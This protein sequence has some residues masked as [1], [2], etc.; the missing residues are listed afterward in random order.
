MLVGLFDFSF[1]LFVF[2]FKQNTAY[3]MRISDWSSDV[4]SSDLTE[5][6]QG[7]DGRA[8]AVRYATDRPAAICARPVAAD[9][10]TPDD[11]RG[12]C[13]DFRP[14]FPPPGRPPGGLP[15]QAGGDGGRIA[16]PCSAPAAY[17]AYPG[18]DTAAGGGK[19]PPRREQ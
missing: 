17:P 4:C 12:G 10:R 15:S 1:L 8:D 11:R 6:Q 14:S 9:R 19:A 3:E 7:S 2:F 5:C 13:A 18:V 16:C